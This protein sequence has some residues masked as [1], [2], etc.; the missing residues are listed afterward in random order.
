MV[1]TKVQ[2]PGEAKHEPEYNVYE[3][4]QEEIEELIQKAERAQREIKEAD[5]CREQN[6]MV[7]QSMLGGPSR[8][9]RSERC[10]KFSCKAQRVG[11]GLA[12]IRKCIRVD[13][14]KCATLRYL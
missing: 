10:E 11:R 2:G 14:S 3:F 8:Q 13:G 4:K 7:E 5:E 6:I 12:D 1:V 9:I